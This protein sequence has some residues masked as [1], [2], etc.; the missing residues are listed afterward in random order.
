M[1]KMPATTST[2]YESGSLANGLLS[3]EARCCF[4]QSRRRLFILIS[5]SRSTGD[6]STSSMQVIVETKRIV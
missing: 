6:A 1:R 5:P 4:R 3:A 2:I